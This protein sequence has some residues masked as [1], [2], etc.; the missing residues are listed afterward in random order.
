MSTGARPIDDTEARPAGG[1]AGEGQH[2]LVQAFRRHA[3]ELVQHLRGRRGAADEAEDL[4]QESFVRLLE[5]EQAGQPVQQ[6]RAWLYRT[7]GN[8]AADA[9]DHRQ[10][11][12][13]VVDAEADPDAVLDLRADPARRAAACEQLDQ[14]WAALT[15][16]PAEVCD[17]FL[18]N[19]FEGLSQREIAQ[20]LDCSEKTVERHVLRALQAC[21]A[22]QGEG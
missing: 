3:R 20:R 13:R 16:L 15:A 22:A 18:L 12:A 2:P 11:V 7:S 10:V 6:P 4:V 19:R 14:V 21:R 1:A 5:A 17:A 9:W 8:L